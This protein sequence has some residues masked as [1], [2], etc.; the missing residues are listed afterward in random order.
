MARDPLDIQTAK[1]RRFANEELAQLVSDL[2]TFGLSVP[3]DKVLGGLVF[4]ARRSPIE[5]VAAVI[6]SY[7]KLEAEQAGGS[8][9]AQSE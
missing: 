5:A 9:S 6:Q 8:D 4:A 7:V 2:Y 3:V 1:I